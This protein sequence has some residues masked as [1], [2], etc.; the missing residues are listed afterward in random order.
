MSTFIYRVANEDDEGPYTSEV[1]TDL[2][3]HL[4]TRGANPRTP[5]AVCEGHF[6]SDLDFYAFVDVESFERWFTPY[7]RWLLK[8]DGFHLYMM[9]VENIRWLGNSGQCTYRIADAV[10]VAKL[11]VWEPRK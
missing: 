3:E 2:A 4:C 7:E 8:A 6:P 9:V 10:R 5:P 1:S 11:P